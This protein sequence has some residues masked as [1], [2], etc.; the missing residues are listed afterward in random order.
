MSLL[1]RQDIAAL[2]AV[3]RVLESPDV[4]GLLQSCTGAPPGTEF[5][6]VSQRTL[7]CTGSQKL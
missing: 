2:P 6:P 5:H 4:A 7:R 1:G 3:V